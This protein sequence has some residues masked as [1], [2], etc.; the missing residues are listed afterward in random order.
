[1]SMVGLFGGSSAGGGAGTEGFTMNTRTRTRRRIAALAS[2]AIACTGLALVTAA[3]AEAVTNAVSTTTDASTGACLNGPGIINC[4]LYSDPEDVWL[5]GL[6]STLQDGDYFLAVL[7]PGAQPDPNDSSTQLLSTDGQLDR[8][9]SVTDGKVTGDAGSGTHT[10]NNNKIQLSPYAPTTNPGG[11]YILAVCALPP[12]GGEVRASDC[13]YDMFK[14]RSSEPPADEQGDPLVVTKDADGDYEL[15]Y[16]W[17]IDKTDDKADTVYGNSP[18]TVTANYKVTLSH[19]SPTPENVTVTGTINVFNPNDNDFS[20]V[21]VTDVLSD[22]T[23]C[24]VTGGNDASVEPGDNYFDYSCS[25]ATRPEAQLDNTATA[26]WPDQSEGQFTPGDAASFTFTSIDFEPPTKFDECVDVSDLFDS[27]DPLDAENLGEVCAGDEDLTFEYPRN[28]AVPE[29]GC[30]SYDN[31]ATYVSTDEGETPETGS[32][33]ASVQVC[34]TFADTGARTMGFWQNKNGQG[35]IKGGPSTA[36]TCNVTTWLRQW[37]PYKDLTANSCADAARYVLGVVKAAEASGASMNKM[38][39]AQMLATSLDVYYTGPGK[40]VGAQKF[41]PSAAIGPVVID[42]NHV[43]ANPSTCSSFQ[44]V[45]A[46]F[47]GADALSVK[48]LITYASEQSA[49]GGNPWYANVKATQGL[50]KNTFDAINNEKAYAAA[51]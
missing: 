44:D 13:K 43:C 37:N 51:P 29:T 17:G 2:T 20:G 4:N 23:V 35:I 3:P 41:L 18:G 48:Q 50:A 9:F 38:L 45:G 19:N 7:E 16:D 14:V 15:A 11:V 34:R 40:Y 42:L 33:S 10:M 39:K 8:A 24:T 36:G 5:S 27:N 25:L 46:A 47:G 12:G 6:P 22:G 21:D 32:D 31:T 49:V 30:Y 1:M 28:L 26:T